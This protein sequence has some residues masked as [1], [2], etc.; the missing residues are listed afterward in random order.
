M[1]VHNTNILIHLIRN[2]PPQVAERMDQ[3]ADEDSLG[4]S[5]ISWAELLR[6]AGTTPCRPQP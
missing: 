5:F 6:G 3:L 2:R 4:M 1:D